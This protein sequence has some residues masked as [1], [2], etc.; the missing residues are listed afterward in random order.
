MN[1][2][3][4]PKLS[5]LYFCACVTVSVDVKSRIVRVK[6][7]R[8]TLIRSFR[9]LQLDIECEKKKLT[10]K[11]WSG[12][13]KELAAIRTICSHIENMMK[14][15]TQVYIHQLL[16]NLSLLLKYFNLKTLTR[17]MTALGYEIDDS[18]L[19]LTYLT[20]HL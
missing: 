16:F 2:I 4:L 1:D 9:H 8:G 19:N 13:R 18:T 20:C 7:P 6:G 15:V 12:K 17:M 3:V 11:K 14:G 10:I 5:S